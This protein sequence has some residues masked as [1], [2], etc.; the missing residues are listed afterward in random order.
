MNNRPSGT[1]PPLNPLPPVVWALALPMNV[2]EAVLQLADA[3]LIGGAEGVGWRLTVLT[4]MAFDPGQLAWMWETGR[5]LPQELARLPAYSFAHTALSHAAFV[6]VFV[7]ALGKFVGEVF[8]PLPLALLFLGS[9]MGAA[10]IYTATGQTQALVGGYPGAFGLI[11]ALL[12][13][14]VIFGLINGEFGSVVADLSGFAAGFL[15]SF[16]VSPGG[17]RRVLAALRSR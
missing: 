1:E 13:I 6:V 12:A 5:F 14:Q 10:L 15:M 9:A 2:L 8:R 17:W 7:L 4:R 16:L 3:G 11:G